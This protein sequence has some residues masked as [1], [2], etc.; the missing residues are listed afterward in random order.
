MWLA[1]RGELGLEGSAASRLLAAR[2]PRL[3]SAARSALEMEARLPEGASRDLVGAH[4]RAVEKALAAHPPALVVPWRAIL[5]K[6]NL[7]SA[8][9][10]VAALALALGVANVRA[11][12]FALIHPGLRAP[13]GHRVASIVRID[14]VRVSPPSYVGEGARELGPTSRIDALRG[15]IV[16]VRIGALTTAL[17]RLELR[18][19]DGY[20]IPV[21]IDDAGR[22]I[23]RFVVSG[24]VTARFAGRVDGDLV[25]DA[26][27]VSIEAAE[28]RAPTVELVEPASDLDVDVATVV[29]AA[30]EAEDDVGLASVDVVATVMGGRE[31]RHAIALPERGAARGSGRVSLSLAELGVEDGD[32]V[33][34]YAEA[35]DGDLVSGPH[36]T[37][38][39]PRSLRLGSASRRS[40][41][42]LEDLAS[43]REDALG[44]LADRIETPVPEE[45]DAAL[46][47]FRGFEL[48]TAGLVDRLT[49]VANGALE[50]TV[51]A[52]DRGI[53]QELARRLGR[54]LERERRLHGSRL[55]PLEARR[56]ADAGAVTELEGAV[57]MLSS[58]LLRARADDAAAIARELEDLR[59][60]MASLLAELRRAHSPEAQR[61]LRTMLAR[62]RQRLA[63]LRERLA[64]ASDGSPREFQNLQER[65]MAR[66]EEALGRMQA[67]LDDDDLDAAARALTGLEQE[68]DLLARAL[69]R[70]RDA[71]AEERFGPRERALA[72]VVDGLMSLEAEQRELASRTSRAHREAADRAIAADAS[73]ARTV[74][75]SLAAEARS[76]AA[77]LVAGAPAGLALGS[78]ERWSE[79]QRRLDDVAAA[80]S[81]GDL[82][83]ARRMTAL[84]AEALDDLTRGI[85]LDALMFPGLDG[86]LPA[87]ARAAREA[88]RRTDR[89]ARAIEASIPDV[90]AHLDGEDR[91]RL[92]S[93]ADRQASA[94]RA[95][96]NLL[97]RLERLPMGPSGAEISGGLREVTERMQAAEA[98]LRG[99]EAAEA[100]RAQDEA[101]RRL[102]EIRRRIESEAEGGGGGGEGSV[103]Q[104]REPVVIP[105]AEAF[106]TPME[107]RRR[108]LDAMREQAPSGF[109]EAIRRYYE[110]LLR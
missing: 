77:P 81:S 100:A 72:D 47:R 78:R 48:R 65:D 84:A 36:V 4:A 92:R 98:A 91:E 90:S 42:A 56:V 10:T 85:E 12:V 27:L 3:V 104:V 54:E 89:L 22:G 51:R 31:V 39:T 101:A 75:T 17:G 60:R 32:V 73:R 46:A 64:R 45:D 6:T 103:A 66:S 1:R 74:S 19:S 62:A 108:I 34:V 40:E 61:E 20:A 37:R 83:E 88:A 7:A 28:D 58:L 97:E 55:A 71:V 9:L 41:H 26:T 76:A 16:E 63:E 94:R 8:G 25:E 11:G 53:Y 23:V 2:D 69:G 105:G 70:S 52:T 30:V 102:T 29:V 14:G 80:L 21:P 82:G 50:S 107:Q 93:D 109:D 79:A 24:T 68:L 33:T 110:A 87:A 57:L 106:E 59:R 44:L 18:F 86:T 43:M 35:R 38:S 96:S 5:S 67:A 99:L 95:A 13:E 49:S 15:A